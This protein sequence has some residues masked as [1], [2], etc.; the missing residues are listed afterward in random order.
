MRIREL[1][2]TSLLLAA[3][4]CS[5]V[6]WLFKGF[7]VAR[8]APA[9]IYI[10]IYIPSP[11]Y[12]S[13]HK[14]RPGSGP[15]TNTH[16]FLSFCSLIW[17]IIFIFICQKKKKSIDHIHF[18]FGHWILNW[19]VLGLQSVR[20]TSCQI[21]TWMAWGIGIERIEVHQLWNP[22]YQPNLS[23]CGVDSKQEGPDR[24]K[25]KGVHRA[26]SAN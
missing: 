3:S 11:N 24:D 10:Y 8:A 2:W 16:V 4:S 26:I 19:I 18:L 1:R 22:G 9:L 5:S 25:I 20:S 15:P 23:L 6:E 14:S 17:S 12:C 13:T 7:A 21:H